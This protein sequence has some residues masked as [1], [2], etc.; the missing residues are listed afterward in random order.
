MDETVRGNLAA[1]EYLQGQLFAAAAE[2][3]DRPADWLTQR[4]AEATAEF[5]RARN[6]TSGEAVSALDTVQRVLRRAARRLEQDSRG[7]APPGR[8][9]GG[10]PLPQSSRSP[11]TDDSDR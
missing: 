9:S 8:E 2:Q 1:L 7:A 3:M 11:S 5:S 4:A 6:L 10:A